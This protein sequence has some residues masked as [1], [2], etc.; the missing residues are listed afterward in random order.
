MGPVEGSCR[1]TREEPVCPCHVPLGSW[2]GRAPTWQGTWLSLR[3][4]LCSPGGS[5]D[6][7]PLAPTSP[8]LPAQADGR[9]GP[10]LRAAPPP[11]DRHPERE[12][13]AER[14]YPG[15]PRRRCPGPLEPGRV[16]ARG[17]GQLLGFGP[18]R[19]E[20]P[21]GDKHVLPLGGMATP[22]V[23]SP[24]ASLRCPLLP[25]PQTPH[26]RGQPGQRGN[27]GTGGPCFALSCV[28]TPSAVLFFSVLGS[29]HVAGCARQFS[30]FSAPCW[31]V[32]GGAF[33]ASSGF[34]C[35]RQS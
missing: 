32:Q 5:G 29:Q 21:T 24:S 11:A 31:A 8:A 23:R 26:P 19:T 33:P 18:R 3:S 13:D 6:R 1:T 2:E 9:H 14:E 34:W 17:G 35:C 7:C 12:H 15:L 27:G 30:T 25:G 28:P 22:G 10:G 16:G 20:V 4:T